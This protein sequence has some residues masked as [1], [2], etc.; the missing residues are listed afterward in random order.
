MKSS[1]LIDIPAGPEELS[2]NADSFD[3]TE[4]FKSPRP[5]TARA[6][7]RPKTA[8]NANHSSLDRSFKLHG[9]HLGKPRMM[10]MRT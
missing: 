4:R 1:S 7:S 5:G 8:T 6:A 10:D 2:P 3:K 9:K